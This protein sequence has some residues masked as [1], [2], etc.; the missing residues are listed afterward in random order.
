MISFF[1]HNARPRKKNI[2]SVQ[3]SLMQTERQS[4]TQQE[5]IEARKIK[6]ST[7]N[8][9]ML[10]WNIKLGTKQTCT[11]VSLMLGIFF[12]C[13]MMISIVIFLHICVWL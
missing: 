5:Y 12:Q 10:R 9:E 13:N 3:V 7:K 8:N 1:T 4:E 2:S 11:T 6:T